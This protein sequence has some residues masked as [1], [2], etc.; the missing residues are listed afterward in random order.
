VNWTESAFALFGLPTREGAGIP[1][2][3]LHSYVT[4]ADVPAVKQFRE[5]L[6]HRQQPTNATFR[7][8][9]A[10]DG[11]VRQ[12]RVFAEP[13]LSPAGTIELIQGAFQDVSA[14][15]HT[16]V[17]LAATRDQL[18]DTEQRVAEEHLLAVR[19]QQAIM[20]PTAEPVAAAGIEVA[21]RYRPV[22]PG[23]LVGGDWYDTGPVRGE[24]AGPVRGEGYRRAG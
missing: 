23:H 24:P 13:V 12:M 2:A 10:D 19:L 7:I 1:L 18:V 5:T 11:S 16:Q 15:Y 8:V 4:A 22:G 9:R 20:P 6:L 17:A 14:E 3:D 21:V